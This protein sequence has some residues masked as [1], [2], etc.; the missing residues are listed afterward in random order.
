M[1]GQREDPCLQ[2]SGGLSCSSQQATMAGRRG[3]LRSGRG[4]S[5]KRERS[6]LRGLRMVA[7]RS[8]LP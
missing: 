8:P 2:G 4:G 6:E 7:Q 1:R 3:E 5:S